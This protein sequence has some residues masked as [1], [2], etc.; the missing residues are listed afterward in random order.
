MDKTTFQLGAKLTK[1]TA[2]SGSIPL[3][4]EALK[5]NYS[6]IRFGSEFC[7]YALPSTEELQ[8]AYELTVDAG[9]EFVY[10]TPRLADKKMI[11]ECTQFLFRSATIRFLLSSP[12]LADKK[13]IIVK[14]QLETLNNMG[15]CT[16]VINDLGALKIVKDLTS[17][18]SH[19]GRQLVYIPS[20]CPWKEITEREVSL[21]TKRK[22]KKIFYQTALNYDPTIIFYKDLGIIGADVDYIPNLF[23]NLKFLIERGLQ[24]DVHMFSI[25]VAITR[26][27]HTARFLGTEDLETCSRFCYT[28]AFMMNN[29]ILNKDLCLYGNTVLKL[30]EPDRKAI[31]LLSRMGVDEFVI[32]MGP[33]VHA[34]SKLPEIFDQIF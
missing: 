8:K 1:L 19:L 28:K 25:P 29:E 17:L 20:R 26:K 34:S 6:V 27:C 24:L 31:S 7:M 33:L 18:K 2:Q 11:I 3:L 16:I 30:V 10:V 14:K 23:P 21:F 9:K 12:R 15:G 22:I 13:M 32:T 4:K 5:K